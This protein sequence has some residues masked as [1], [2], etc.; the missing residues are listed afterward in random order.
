[1]NGFTGG[2]PVGAL[3]FFSLASG[4]PVRDSEHKQALNLRRREFLCPEETEKTTGLAGGFAL[5]GGTQGVP[6]ADFL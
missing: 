5:A 6:P 3:S 1:M 2:A 4:N